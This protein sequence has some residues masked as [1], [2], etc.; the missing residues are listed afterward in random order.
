MTYFINADHQARFEQLVQEAGVGERETTV[1]TVLYLL[2]SVPSVFKNIEMFFNVTG[3]Y[4][5]SYD[6]D[7]IGLSTGERVIVAL[8]YNLFNG[9]VV[10][11]TVISPHYALSWLDHGLRQVYF[12]ALQLKSGIA[13]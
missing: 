2:S 1:Q 6:E 12:Q 5:E 7:S 4:M 10:D 8:A 9:Y 13:S 11:Q 3:K